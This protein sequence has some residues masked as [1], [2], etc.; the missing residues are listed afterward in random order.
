MG[1]LRLGR[2][3]AEW[4][5]EEGKG[6]AGETDGERRS[7]VREE[8]AKQLDPAGGNRAKIGKIL[9]LGASSEI[10]PGPMRA[11]SH[12]PHRTGASDALV[13][14]RPRCP[15]RYNNNSS[16]SSS[17]YKRSPFSSSTLSSS[18][19]FGLSRSFLLLSPFFPDCITLSLSL[20]SAFVS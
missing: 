2:A 18:F 6:D 8:T 13:F 19:V 3:E 7:V 5:R 16:S 4:A 10:P 11:R 17:T 12:W 14:L 15:T 9:R 20:A 1:K